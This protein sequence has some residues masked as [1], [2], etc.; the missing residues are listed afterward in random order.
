MGRRELLLARRPADRAVNPHLRASRTLRLAPAPLTS[1][2]GRWR[3]LPAGALL[4][5]G[6]LDTCPVH[7]SL[8]DQVIQ[9]PP[10]QGHQSLLP[11]TPVVCR[12]GHQHRLSPHV[13]GT[14][15]TL[16]PGCRQ[17]TEL[18][19][20]PGDANERWAGCRLPRGTR[21]VCRLGDRRS[22]RRGPQQR[23][24]KIADRSDRLVIG[25]P[26]AGEDLGWGLSAKH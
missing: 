8:R 4:R 10:K 1:P 5:L 7:L 21:S 6:T 3:G 24:S 23:A 18:A 12:Q 26:I 9:A 11:T 20:P 22:R 15:P 14:Q 19:P 13:G 17:S 16:R 25:R 2:A